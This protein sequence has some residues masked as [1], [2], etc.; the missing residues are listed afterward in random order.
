M[1]SFSNVVSPILINE[2][3]KPISDTSFSSL[4]LSDND[5]LRLKIVLKFIFYHCVLYYV[6]VKSN[7]SK[8]ITS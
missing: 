7:L 3:I 6:L 2:N 8:Q 1:S 5:F 4:P